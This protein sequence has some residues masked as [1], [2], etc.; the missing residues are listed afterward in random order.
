VGARPPL[1]Y[2]STPFHR[3]I[4]GVLIEGGDVSHRDGSGGESIYGG[5]F[6]DENLRDIDAAGLVCMANSG[7]NTNT[8]R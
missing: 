6:E 1:A 2:R 4:D 3:L 8:S 5:P 7:R